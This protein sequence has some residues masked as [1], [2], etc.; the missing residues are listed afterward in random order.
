MLI[1]LVYSPT[2]YSR[3]SVY[4]TSPT[5]FITL[6]DSVCILL[7]HF[8]P[9]HHSH[10]QG[11]HLQDSKLFLRTMS[12]KPPPSVHLHC[13]FYRHLC[14]LSLIWTA[15][16]SSSPA[17]P[18][19][20]FIFLSCSLLASWGGGAASAPWRHPEKRVDRG[21]KLSGFPQKTL[22]TGLIIIIKVSK[23]TNF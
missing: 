22:S 5:I 13:R 21:S 16:S 6:I 17:L 23:Y 14:E 11:F 8:Y 15:S 10:H 3:D 19:E 2:K 18:S 4:T 1:C 12:L 7:K 9:H 20:P